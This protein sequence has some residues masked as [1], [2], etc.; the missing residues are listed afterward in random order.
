MPDQGNGSQ[1]SE[2]LVSASAQRG[3]CDKDS[4]S[5]SNDSKTAAS[6]LVK[7]AKSRSVEGYAS[8]I[9]KHAA[10]CVEAIVQMGLLFVK[11]KQE[12]PHGDFGSLFEPGVLHV[13]QRTAEK[14]M[15]IAR[16]VTLANSTNWPNLPGALNSLAI[17]ARLNDDQLQAGIQTEKIHRSITIQE[18]TRLVHEA[19]AEQYYARSCPRLA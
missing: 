11:A 5:E 1:P 8:I 15:R 6:P 18:A 13:D 2:G 3:T 16:K 17:L 19:Q 7:K 4:G 9:N 12:L 10:N 14:M